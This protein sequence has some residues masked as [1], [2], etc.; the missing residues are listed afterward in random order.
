MTGRVPA[1]T[2]GVIDIER[3]RSVNIGGIGAA[4]VTLSLEPK[5]RQLHSRGPVPTVVAAA[6]AGDASA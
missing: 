2:V 1:M 3:E 5:R 6:V 4:I